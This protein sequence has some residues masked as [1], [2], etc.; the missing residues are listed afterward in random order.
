MVHRRTLFM[1]IYCLQ[2]NN[3][4]ACTH[5]DYIHGNLF[6]SWPGFTMR[7]E[8]KRHRQ[9]VLRKKIQNRESLCQEAGQGHQPWSFKALN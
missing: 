6:I 2:K 3:I 8:G 7:Q 9:E 1:Q 4:S 5:Q